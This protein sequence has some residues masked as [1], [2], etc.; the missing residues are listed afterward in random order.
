MSV[1]T[2]R[3]TGFR[4][5]A[6]QFLADLAQNN[7]RSW[8]QPRKDDYEEL[9]KRPLE[10]LCVALD[11]RFRARSI[12]LRADPRRSPFRIYR[13]VRFAKDKSPYKTNLGASFPWDG[14]GPERSK[15]VEGAGPG[16]IAG[17]FHLEPGEIFAGGGMW[18]P[19]RSRLVAFRKRIVEDPDSVRAAFGEP[20]FVESFGEIGGDRLQRVP[21]G[22]PADHPSADLLRLKDVVFSRRLSDADAASPGLPDLLADLYAAAT[23]ALRFLARL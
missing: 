17:Y 7:D 3:F 18:H 16:G 5:E 2:D 1:A 9:L 15:G 8:F 11:E 20:D 21:P 6:I 10:A 23:P 19:E 14:S 12:P 22:Y 13:D 4:P